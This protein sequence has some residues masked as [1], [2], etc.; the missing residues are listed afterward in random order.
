[1]ERIRKDLGWALFSALSLW[2]LWHEFI[3]PQRAG[4]GV[5]E[6]EITSIKDPKIIEGLQR[7]KENRFYM[8]CKMKAWMKALIETRQSNPSASMDNIELRFSP[9]ED[10]VYRDL[11]NNIGEL[12]GWVEV[13]TP[14]NTTRY[15][16]VC[17]AEYI[18]DLTKW[19]PSWTLIDFDMDKVSS[20]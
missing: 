6:Q 12:T 17:K 10:T 16:Y 3:N 13:L 11:D 20:P 7:L 1:M 8:E 14:T 9:P 18:F 15:T 5:A 19:R 4:L 2:I